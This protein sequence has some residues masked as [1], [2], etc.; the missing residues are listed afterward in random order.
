MGEVIDLQANPSESCVTTLENAVE[1]AKANPQYGVIVAM[2]DSE[3]GIY[4]LYNE[5]LTA[6]GAIVACELVKAMN[7]EVLLGE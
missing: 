3:G 7:V 5:E 6:D 1:H 2:V 4:A